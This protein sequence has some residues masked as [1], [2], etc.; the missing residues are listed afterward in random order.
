MV[1]FTI[2]ADDD[3]RWGSSL[4]LSTIQT[5]MASKAVNQFIPFSLCITRWT[6]GCYS[7]LL[8]RLACYIAETC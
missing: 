2:E 3:G 8:P 6:F 1:T 4:S 5:Q 7:L